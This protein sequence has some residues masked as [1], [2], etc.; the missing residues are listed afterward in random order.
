M[1]LD[2]VTAV[3]RPR[4]PWEAAD[5]GARMARRDVRQ[6]YGVWFA[7]TLPLLVLTLLLIYFTPFWGWAVFIYWWLEP[8]VDGPILHVLSR[9]LFGEETS[10]AAAMKQAP[11]LAMRNWIFWLSPYRFH[12]S[13]SVAMPV[14]QLEGLTGEPRRTRTRILNQVASNHGIGLT[15]AYQ[16]LALAISIGFVLLGFAFIPEAYQESLGLSWFSNFTDG[17]T[18]ASQAVLLL[19][20]YAAQ[21]ALQP[22]FVGGGFGLYINARTILESWDIEVEFRRMLERRKL[23]AGATSITLVCIALMFGQPADAQE[24]G[25]AVPQEELPQ[26]SATWEADEVAAAL[27]VVFETEAL[28]DVRQIEEWVANDPDDKE[29]DNDPEMDG[30]VDFFAAIGRFISFIVEFGLWFV[31]L[32][33]LIALI[34]TS[35]RWLP[36]VRWRPAHVEPRR[37]IT[38]AQGEVSAETLPA[39]IPAVVLALWQKG[40][41]R[42]ALSL[43]YRGSV[44]A[45]VTQ[46]GVRLPDSATEGAC[47]TAV[48]EQTTAAHS[49][50]FRKVVAAWV[51]CAYGTHQPK[52]EVVAELCNNWKQHY[53]ATS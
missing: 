49:A 38:L 40:E 25:E 51:W 18:R 39:D 26:I 41:H 1:N 7:M 5:F 46:H 13:R 10:V 17:E 9:R 48:T 24:V 36:Y 35:R 4:G 6:I 32:I 14:T 3:L 2:A 29:A 19:A 43:L 34:L 15:I 42:L 53:G 47:V 27:A 11:R 22:W 45:A 23:V 44:V 12:F 37:R 31:V 30:I 8:L 21:T 16:H 33:I 52:S 50:F 28:S 20:F